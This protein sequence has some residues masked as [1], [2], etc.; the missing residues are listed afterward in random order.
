MNVSLNA[1]S[2]CVGVVLLLAGS[3][4]LFAKGQ[5]DYAIMAFGTA[6]TL[7]G[8]SF[9]LFGL[10][11]EVRQIRSQVTDVADVQSVV[12][13]DL[14]DIRNNPSMP[15]TPTVPGRSHEPCKEPSNPGT[16]T[17]ANT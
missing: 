5:Y 3:M 4:L 9:S 2:K 1:A 12:A 6:M 15:G 10:K 16:I 14:Q 17:E 8:N 11:D 13:S 7:S